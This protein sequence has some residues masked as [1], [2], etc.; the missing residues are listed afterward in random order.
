M[1]FENSFVRTRHFSFRIYP[2]GANNMERL[3][4]R[5]FLSV[6]YRTARQVRFDFRMGLHIVG[7]APV[8]IP[9][10]RHACVCML[11]T[12]VA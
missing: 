11:Y 9:E 10:C 2:S 4:K 3:F 8:R 6:D 5:S 1:S 12:A 7:C